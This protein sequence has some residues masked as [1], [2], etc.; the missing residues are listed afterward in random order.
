MM[1]F[2]K[3]TEKKT[4][5]TAAL[6]KDRPFVVVQTDNEGNEFVQCGRECRWGLAA[7]DH[8]T[9]RA[10]RNLGI[11]TYCY[12]DQFPDSERNA[13]AAEFVDKLDN[14]MLQARG[15]SKKDGTAWTEHELETWKC[16]VR[17]RDITDIPVYVKEE[18]IALSLSLL[19]SEPWAFC[20]AGKNAVV[21]YNIGNV[22][23]IELNRVID[24]A[25]GFYDEYLCSRGPVHI[26]APW[27]SDEEVICHLLE[28]ACK[29]LYGLTV[30]ATLE[31]PEDLVAIKYGITV[32][33]PLNPIDS[34][35]GFDSYDDALE[36]SRVIQTALPG[37]F[38]RVHKILNKK[39]QF[40]D[41]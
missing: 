21:Y 39:L 14:E 37:V 28:R 18:V 6:I 32:T 27:I 35:I 17:S 38:T 13:R 5:L 24:E 12:C 8:E 11:A 20:Q 25:S 33:P 41:E 31:P 26:Y 2:K 10:V 22:G 16:L 3:N 29:R 15:I 19:N 7:G 40:I 1:Y 4:D 34:T 30:K 9:V 23:D 36:V